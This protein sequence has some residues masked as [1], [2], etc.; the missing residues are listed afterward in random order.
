MSQA[1]GFSRNVRYLLWQEGSQR[2]RWPDRVA[3]WAGCSSRRALLLL[4][5][6]PPTATELETIARG[7]GL[8]EEEL[9]YQDLVAGIDVLRENTR[10]LLAGLPHGDKGKLAAYVG[11]RAGTLSG[12]LGGKP[13]RSENLKKLGAY[14]GLRPDTDLAREA[15]FLSLHPVT[16]MEQKTWLHRQVD[17]LTGDELR[18]LF[19]AL[20][21]LLRDD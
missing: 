12:W 15:L 8:S 3:E 21:K 5:G 1:D 19:P 18:A 16:E 14:F 11:V 10:F 2:D 13:P 20:C 9:R 7:A 17:A 4:G 6:S